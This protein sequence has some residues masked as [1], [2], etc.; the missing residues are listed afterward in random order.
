MNQRE[1]REVQIARL[2]VEVEEAT[3]AWTTAKFNRDQVQV[4]ETENRLVELTT[5]LNVLK[6]R[7]AV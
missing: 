2:E 4:K 7:R 1:E 5:V 3:A 6:M